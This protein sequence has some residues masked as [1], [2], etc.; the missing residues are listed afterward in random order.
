MRG[1]DPSR[2]RPP[3]R[4]TRGGRYRHLG[5][6]HRPAPPA[7]RI[8][9][10][11][12]GLVVLVWVA[13]ELDVGTI[14]Q[15]D[16]VLGPLQGRPCELDLAQVP[17][18]DSTALISLLAHRRQSRAAG[19]SLRVVAPSPAIAQLLTRIGATALL[20][21]PARHAPEPGSSARE[22]QWAD[23][24]TTT[25]ASDVTGTAAQHGHL[26]RIFHL[27]HILIGRAVQRG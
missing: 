8:Q 4:P 11:E 6:G 1:N 5:R 2:R 17:F 16:A 15:L 7:L 19:G 23:P 3:A 21:S 13:G 27:L 20:R 14:A 12:V 18:M 22:E 9:T 26:V 24:A 25:T 10:V